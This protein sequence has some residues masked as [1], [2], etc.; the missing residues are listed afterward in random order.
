MKVWIVFFVAAIML[1]AQA[2]MPKKMVTSI[3]LP[4]IEDQKAYHGHLNTVLMELKEGGAIDYDL[5]IYEDFIDQQALYES[6]GT[7]A[8]EGKIDIPE[9]ILIPMMYFVVEKRGENYHYKVYYSLL[10]LAIQEN[11]KIKKILNIKKEGSDI[12]QTM[13]QAIQEGFDKF[14][15]E[16]KEIP[17]SQARKKLVVLMCKQRPQVPELMIL[18][19]LIEYFELTEEYDLILPKKY[20]QKVEEMVDKLNKSGKDSAEIKGKIATEDTTPQEI[21]GWVMKKGLEGT[22]HYQVDIKGPHRHPS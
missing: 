3:V 13:H 15:E 12:H 20:I 7:L 2:Q 6:L 19:K 1:T 21:L 18:N 14:K 4:D 11:M 10:E 17:A 22:L 8:E 9:S 5:Q 16:K